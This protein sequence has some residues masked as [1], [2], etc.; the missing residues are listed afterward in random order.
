ML[1]LLL[2]SKVLMIIALKSP[3]RLK[4][5]YKDFKLSKFYTIIMKMVC[6]KNI[7]FRRFF[8]RISKKYSDCKDT[9]PTFVTFKIFKSTYTALKICK[10]Q[11][12]KKKLQTPKFS[13]RLNKVYHL[14][15]E[16]HIFKH[17]T[18]TSQ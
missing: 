14:I 8:F 17:F 1:L 9:I 2:R 18:R 10:L 4:F 3:N 12:T 5:K 11:N 15:Y 13:H 6:I 16:A 7:F